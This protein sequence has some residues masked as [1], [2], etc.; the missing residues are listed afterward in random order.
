MVSSETCPSITVLSKSFCGVLIDFNRNKVRQK[1]GQIFDGCTH[2]V[3]IKTFYMLIIK[4]TFK[5][6]QFFFHKMKDSKLFGKE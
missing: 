4:D 2:I 1:L 5:K 3:L 6:I